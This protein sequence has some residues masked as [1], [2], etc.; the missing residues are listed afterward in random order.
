MSEFEKWEF[1][2]LRW[3]EFASGLGVD[4]ITSANLDLDKYA[5]GFSEEYT[6]TP[7]RLMDGR[8]VAGYHLMIKDGKVSGGPFIPK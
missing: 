1:G 3:C 2:C 8:E 7:D 4:L 6:H 5:W